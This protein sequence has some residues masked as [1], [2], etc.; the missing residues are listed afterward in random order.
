MVYLSELAQRILAEL[1][2][3]GEEDVATLLNTCMV[4]SG[5]IEQVAEISAAFAEL[6]SIKLAS[7][8]ISRDP[9]GRLVD[10]PQKQALE[11]AS[12]VGKYVSYS[13]ADG[14]W[15][16]VPLSVPRS[17]TDYFDPV[18]AVSTPEGRDVAFEILDQRGY[19]WW[20]PK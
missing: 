11:Y 20:R 19:Q 10:L 12:T 4:V 6:I 7:I 17:G 9:G 5:Q 8:A 13:Q 15:L 14:H 18:H 1:E 2:E 3:A 16:N